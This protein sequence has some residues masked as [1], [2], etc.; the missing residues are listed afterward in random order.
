MKFTIQS[1]FDHPVK[2]H[3]PT[4]E[5]FT[6]EGFVGT[7]NVLPANESTNRALGKARDMLNK[8]ETE[9]KE[10]KPED[11][12]AR[13]LE[14]NILRIQGMIDQLEQAEADLEAC[15]VGVKSGLFDDQGKTIECTASVRAQL[16]GIPYVRSAI[17]AAYKQAMDGRE[18]GNSEALPAP[19]AGAATTTAN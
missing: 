9:A 14:A 17:K 7:F 19:S 4:A 16:L 12:S 15:F 18:S 3:K 10:G 1:T 11:E 8:L 2:I 13:T 5:G 6:E